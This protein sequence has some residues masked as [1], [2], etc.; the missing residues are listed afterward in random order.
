MDFSDFYYFLSCD[1]GN[2]TFRLKL[3]D[4]TDGKIIASITHP[5]GIKKIYDRWSGK[6]HA[7]NREHFYFLHLNECIAE[8]EKE[9]KENL[10]G[11]PVIISGM[12]SSSIGIKELPYACLPL[13]LE[14]P[15]LQS[16][17]IKKTKIFPH[18]VILISGL[19]TH[20][21]IMRG[22]ETQLL[23]LAEHPDI[24]NS[25]CIFPGTHSKHIFIKDSKV[26]GFETFLTG[27]LFE[28]LSTK[29]ILKNS[30]SPSN[31]P[32]NM[33]AFR[34]GVQQSLD[35]NF[36]YSL[37]QVRVKDLLHKADK[38]ANYDFLSGLVIGA[39]LKQ[40]QNH[41]YEQ[42]FLIGEERLQAFYS[43]ALEFLGLDHF[44][45][46]DPGELAV[47]GH[48]FILSTTRK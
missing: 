30:V 42:L 25:A 10:G 35:R 32:G 18:E 11:I 1:W 4:I 20:N 7:Q 46:S 23:G 48:R 27:E 43:A 45:I 34:Q 6:G 15:N 19:R 12:A 47:K 29:S 8:F 31:E 33:D 17:I 21:D 38:E 9:L 16:T 22:E 3:V 14:N 26:V 44:S 39:G 24:A 2:S 13:S 5:E 28:L 37:F 41:H 40:L 36:L